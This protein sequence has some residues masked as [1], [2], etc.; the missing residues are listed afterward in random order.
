MGS[1]PI[2]VSSVADL[3]QAISRQYFHRGPVTDSNSPESRSD[4]RRLDLGTPIG[5]TPL[6][7]IQIG[8]VPTMGAL[9]AGHLFLVRKARAE[10]DIVVVSIF[11]N[12]TQ[13]AANEDFDRYPRTLEQDLSL[14]GTEADIVWVPTVRDVYP[15]GIQN[16]TVVSVPGVSQGL[17]ARSRPDHF[18]G[19][20][21]V[22]LRLLNAVSPNR[23]Y[24]GEKDFQQLRV[25]QKMVADLLLPVEVVGCPIVREGSGLAMSSRNAYL[26][27]GSRKKAAAI[28]QAMQWGQMQYRAGATDAQAL[29][30]TMVDAFCLAT[31]PE[32]KIDY[33]TIVDADTLSERTG[34]V[35]PTDRIMVAVF[36][37]GVRLIDNLMVGNYTAK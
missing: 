32:K 1:K 30:Q 28:Y 2:V 12:P 15:G 18:Q 4:Y 10:N 35:E 11:V 26:T 14:L 31:D 21:M 19:V 33:W 5:A 20:A 29:I 37:D 16:T 6:V 25:I 24:F 27:P 9:H 3:R 7:S 34:I 22:V 8:F 36:W 13:F 23:A 17:C